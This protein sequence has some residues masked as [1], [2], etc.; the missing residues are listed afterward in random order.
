MYNHQVI[1]SMFND[2]KFFNHKKKK[3]EQETVSPH[4]NQRTCS[5]QRQDGVFLGLQ[6]APGGEA[7]KSHWRLI[8]KAFYAKRHLL[9]KSVVGRVVLKNRNKRAIESLLDARLDKCDHNLK[10]KSVGV[11]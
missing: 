10:D 2:F 7:T 4:V 11:K 5:N 9:K 8:Q 3:Q 1:V 6:T